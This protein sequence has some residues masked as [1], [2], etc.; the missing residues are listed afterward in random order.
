VSN[1][2]KQTLEIVVQF[3]PTPSIQEEF[4]EFVETVLS[5]EENKEKKDE[6]YYDRT[7]TKN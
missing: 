4:L 7:K 2:K 1:L 5:F 6:N 3:E